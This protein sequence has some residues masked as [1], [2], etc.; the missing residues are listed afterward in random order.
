MGGAEAEAVGHDAVQFDAVFTLKHEKGVR[1]KEKFL[2]SFGHTQRKVLEF[3]GFFWSFA[4]GFGHIWT[5]PPMS[6]HDL[7]RVP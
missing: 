2:K 7:N 1:K 6:R 4:W 3:S 5:P